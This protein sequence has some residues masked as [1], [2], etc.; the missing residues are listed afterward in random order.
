MSDPVEPRRSLERS[1][2]VSFFLR[3][4]RLLPQPYTSADV[5]RMT[6]GYFALGALDLL[7]SLDRIPSQERLELVDWVYAQQSPDGGFAGSPSTA[8]SSSSYSTTTTITTAATTATKRSREKYARPNVAMT[9]SALLILAIL[10]DD[11]S[12]LDRTQLLSFLHSLQCP[13]E[14]SFT[15]EPPPPTAS[16]SCSSSSPRADSEIRTSTA[17]DKDVDVDRDP[18]FTY[19]ALAIADMLGDFDSID[20]D[21]AYTYLA[22]CQRYDGGFGANSTQES[23][24]GMSYCCL[25]GLEILERFNRRRKDSS[26]MN[27][28]ADASRYDVEAAVSFLVHRQVEPLLAPAA[29]AGNGNEPQDNDDEEEEEEEEEEDKPS[30][31]G[32]FQGRTAK[33]PPDVC[34]SFWNGASLSLLNQHGL[35]DAASDTA[36]VLSCQSVVGG[37]SKV[38]ADHPDLLHSYLGLAALSLHFHSQSQS[39]HQH[40]HQHQAQDQNIQQD[41]QQDG[42]DDSNLLPDL[43]LDPDL[44]LGLDLKPLDPV[45]NCTL[46]TRA[47]ISSHLGRPE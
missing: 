22:S 30:W 28:K 44:E 36:Y 32:G 38:P 11:F 34:Y 14:G 15:D 41:Q 46:E 21:R 5:Q 42:Q 3:C 6:L 13:L 37:I 23:H 24:S 43:D 18:R 33:L 9:Y 31:K 29:V 16:S 25:A 17:R 47:W 27:V 2:H 4:L 7:S 1:K 45:L 12:R 19:C 10:R 8:S 40:Q 35:I 20:T 26:S 39:Q